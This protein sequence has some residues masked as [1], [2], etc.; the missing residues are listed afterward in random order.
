MM[1]I[2]RKMKIRCLIGC[3]LLWAAAGTAAIAAPPLIGADG[4]ALTFE[5]SPHRVVSL[6]PAVTEAIV[7]IGAA[8]VLCGITYHDADLPGMADTA[9]VGGFSAPSVE[10]VKVLSPD[11]IFATDMHT[12]IKK[13]FSRPSCPVVM[14]SRGSLADRLTVIEQIGDLFDKTAAARDLTRSIEADL[15]MIKQKTEAIAPDRRK[16]VIRLMGR[17]NVMTPGA[18]SFQTEMIRAAG[19]I[20]PAFTEK[21]PV[22]EVSKQQWVDFNPQIIY[23]CGRER[24]IA[25]VF[26]DKPGWR[27]VDAVKNNRIYF[28]PCDLTCRASVNTGGFVSWLAAR[29]Y[30]E[31]FADAANLVRPEKVVRQSPVSQH[32]DYIKKAAIAESHIYDFVNKTLILDLET[33]MTVLSS[34]EGW[35]TEIH[36]VGNHYASPPC[37]AVAHSTALGTFRKRVCRVIDRGPKRISLLFTGADMDNLAVTEKRYRQITVWAYVT[38]GVESNAL[39]MGSDSGLFYEKPGTINIILMTNRRLSPRAMTR[40]IITATEAKTAALLDMDI[41]SSKA[42]GAYRA[43]GT[44]TDNI[45]VVQGKGSPADSTGGHSKLG[46]LIAKAV[47]DGVRTAIG[48]QNHLTAGRT[49][50]QRLK[51]RDISIFGL[52]G[53]QSC[54]CG[55][56]GPELAGAMEKILLDPVYANFIELSLALSDDYKKGLV[57][58]LTAFNRLADEMTTS[59]AGGPVTGEKTLVTQKDIPVVIR[60]ALNAVLT[61]LASREP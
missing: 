61:G 12:A 40:A 53:G 55:K 10:A 20:P 39:R 31:A 37:W 57:S 60:T 59:I 4:K 2:N 21:G 54:E 33:P 19:G 23:G 28:F 18:D 5:T 36:A 48:R 32:P 44:G 26:F 52:L 16:R 29:I 24:K 27:D 58:D 41:R 9:V 14:V 30:H 42:S 8:D 45:I 25:S 56:S 43:T 6:V 35:R 13:A 3:A 7:A 50:F 11:L 15:S 22:V 1:M 34:L 47:D 38:A 46:E 17:K 49:V 51:E